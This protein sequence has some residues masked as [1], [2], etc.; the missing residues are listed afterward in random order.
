M[1]PVCRL[2]FCFIDYIFHLREASQFWRYNLLVFAFRVC[3]TCVIAW[4]WVPVPMH[5][6]FLLTLSSISFSVPGFIMRYLIHLKL[7]FVY[8]DTIG[9]ICI[10][11]HIN[12][13]EN[14]FFI[15]LYDFWLLFQKSGVHRCV[16]YYQGLQ[17]NSINPHFCFYANTKPPILLLWLYSVAWSQG[18]WC[19]QKLSYCPGLFCLSWVY[20]F[21]IKSWALSSWVLWRIVLG[22]V[23]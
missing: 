9:S 23:W 20:C 18:W 15:P 12:M 21:S 2:P 3:A 14:A 22:F 13:H 5:S 7:S 10:L 8:G 1:L 11:L 6:R 16:D 4:K 19:I 17:F